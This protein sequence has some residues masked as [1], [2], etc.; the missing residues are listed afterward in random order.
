M[1]IEPIMLIILNML[2]KKL[3]EA[4]TWATNLNLFSDIIII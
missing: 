1:Q 3:L 2:I 4:A